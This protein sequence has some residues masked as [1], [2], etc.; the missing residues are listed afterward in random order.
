[1]RESHDIA[2]KRE[3][4]ERPGAAGQGDGPREVTR[5]LLDWSRGDVRARDEL[6]PLVYG[7]LRR[8][9]AAYLRRERTGH[10]L[11]PTALVHEAYLRMV[12]QRSVIWQN[13]AHFFAIAAQLMRR[14]LVDHAR[15]QQRAKR[16][17]GAL[18][19]TLDE[20]LVQT[21]PPDCGVLLLDQALT[22]LT[23]LDPRQATIVELR[24]FGGLA[25][26]EVA[27]VLRLSRSTVTREWQVARAW[28]YRRMTT[29]RGQR[30]R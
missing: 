4:G 19:V 18:R 11:V 2:P 12:D 5:L 16:P 30:A 9:A 24:Y 6:M 1:M 27:K 3:P 26:D 7:E 28:L 21:N 17:D 10:T 25:E 15:G 23:A 14:V 13:R 29:G 8:R 20:R 22:E